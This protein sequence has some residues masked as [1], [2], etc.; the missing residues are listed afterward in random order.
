MRQ[1]EYLNLLREELDNAIARGQ[2][3]NEELQ[4][5]KNKNDGIAISAQKKSLYLESIIDTVG[6]CKISENHYVHVEDI[7]HRQVQSDIPDLKYKSERQ[8]VVP[9]L[10][11]NDNSDYHCKTLAVNMDYLSNSPTLVKTNSNPVKTYETVFVEEQGSN[12]DDYDLLLQ[13]FDE[14][15]KTNEE[16]YI[17]ID[18]LRNKL[19]EIQKHYEN[20]II[21]FST[22]RG[23]K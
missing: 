3:A 5:L 19:M 22:K 12:Y 20:L 13:D 11:F 9:I 14:L 15:K 10:D 8:S 21:E 17:E 4:N 16:Y 6:D 2:I 18:I 23:V 7:N 1:E